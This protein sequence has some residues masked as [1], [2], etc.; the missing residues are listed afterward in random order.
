M[1]ES[2]RPQFGQVIDKG[3]SKSKNTFQT[4]LSNYSKYIR[5]YDKKATFDEY[6]LLIQDFCG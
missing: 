3:G 6:A 1:D 5:K 4:N 2:F